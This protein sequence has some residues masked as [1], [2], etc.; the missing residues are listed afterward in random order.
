[1][2]YLGNLKYFSK[3]IF[4]SF[5][6]FTEKI[7]EVLVLVIGVVA[8]SASATHSYGFYCN[9]ILLWILQPISLLKQGFKF[10]DDQTMPSVVHKTE[11]RLLE[12][13]S[14]S[15]NPPMKKIPFFF[16]QLNID[17]GKP[18]LIVCLIIENLIQFVIMNISVNKMLSNIIFIK[19]LFLFLVD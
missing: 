1:M 10:L 8:D 11:C 14:N 17:N 9:P 2:Q 16:L 5:S 13:F 6:F 15:K 4:L 12:N 3:I 7:V 18:T 19:I